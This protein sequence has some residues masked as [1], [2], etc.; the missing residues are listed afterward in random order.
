LQA[1]AELNGAIPLSF[2]FSRP[3]GGA[4]VLNHLWSKM[5]IRSTIER[6]LAKRKFQAP[7]ERAIF[8]MVSNRALNPAS[9]LAYEDWVREDVY[10]PALPEVPVQNLYRAMDFLLEASEQL[11]EEVFFSGANLLNL[12]VDLLYF[13]TTSTYFEVEDEDDK[14]N[15]KQYL[16]KKV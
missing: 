11:Q 9:K 12:E 7:L 6:M 3:I 14:E 13:D 10:I 5:G 16:R 15:Q 1:E 2:V 4:W 8:A